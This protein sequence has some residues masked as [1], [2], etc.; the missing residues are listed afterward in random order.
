MK[1]ARIRMIGS[2]IPINQSKAPLPKPMLASKIL[3]LLFN[4]GKLHWF[5]PLVPSSGKAE[6]I[7][8]EIRNASSLAELIIGADRT[9]QS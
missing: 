5:A 9:R 6:N 7:N 1:N 4:Q 8:K 3:V 2:G